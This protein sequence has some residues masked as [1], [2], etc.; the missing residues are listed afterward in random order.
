[1][2]L[3]CAIVGMISGIISG[4]FSSGGGM[5]IVPSLQYIF[6]LDQKKSRAT[7]I[8]IILPMVIAA[9]IVYYSKNFLDWETGILCSIRWRNWRTS[10]SKNLKENV[11]QVIKNNI[12][13]FSNLCS[14]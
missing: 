4:M 9:G 2:I 3:I 12:Y 8:F 5:I 14:Y 10:R 1:M 13:I 11:R 7:S 6:K